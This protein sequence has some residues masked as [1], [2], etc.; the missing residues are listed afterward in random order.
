MLKKRLN[1]FA[2]AFAGIVSLF[3]SEANA[4]IHLVAAILVLIAGFF[5]EISTVEWC[6]V[7]LC[8]AL[9]FSAE[10]LNT[11]VEKLTDLVTE[12]Y[13]PLAKNAKDI[14]AGAVLIIAIGAA[15]A[16]LLIF[17]PKLLKINIL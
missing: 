3:R 10:A 11:A 17:L 5:F 6:I 8:I 4:K 2:Y 13:H 16:G 1:S 7:A 9:V 12:D 15:T 14:A